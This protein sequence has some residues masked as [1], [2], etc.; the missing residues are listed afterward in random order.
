MEEMKIN[1]WKLKIRNAK[2]NV[3]LKKDRFDMFQ[4]HRSINDG[5]IDVV[6]KVKDPHGTSTLDLSPIT[7]ATAHAQNANAHRRTTRREYERKKK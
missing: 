7:W 5:A 4:H 2:E 1:G 3:V 6:T